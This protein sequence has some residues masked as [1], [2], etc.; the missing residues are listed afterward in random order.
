MKHMYDPEKHHR[1]S[2]RLKE[3]DYS[4]AGA[5]FVTVCIKNKVQL[6]GEIIHREMLLSKIGKVAEK[7]WNEIPIHYPRVQLDKYIVMPNHI[8]GIIRIIDDVG[9]EDF[10]PLQQTQSKINQFQKI[11]PKSLG[12]I[13][14]GF[15]IGITKWCNQ[16]KYER[17]AWQRNY[18]EH[19][20]RNEEELNRIREYIVNNPLRWQY[21]R[22]N[23]NRTVVAINAGVKNL[24]PLQDKFAHFEEV[25]YGKK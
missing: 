15:K 14:R 8:H 12:S 20:I 23:P 21:D 18:H 9:A 11:I 17:F 16:C 13:I 6:L 25:I 4:R 19:I 2:I 24:Q 3:Y 5:Y 22:E 7:C 1:R 10:Q